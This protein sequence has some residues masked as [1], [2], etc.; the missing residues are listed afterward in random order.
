MREAVR[1][2]IVIAGEQGRLDF[3]EGA[4]RYTLHEYNDND[5]D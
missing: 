3:A 1:Q 2:N 4:R 5:L